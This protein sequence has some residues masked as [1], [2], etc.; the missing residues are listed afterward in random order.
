MLSNLGAGRKKMRVGQSTSANP[1]AALKR[2]G[3]NP[4]LGS[5][6]G[7][8]ATQRYNATGVTRS[9]AGVGSNPAIARLVKGGVPKT[10]KMKVI[11]GGNV[12]PEQVN[13]LT[14]KR[15][16]GKGILQSQGTNSNT[17]AIRLRGK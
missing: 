7:G 4:G 2:G 11:T 14:L 3:G 15:G 5:A 12:G 17:L 9:G 16:N 10:G 6:G 13:G 8:T 1:G